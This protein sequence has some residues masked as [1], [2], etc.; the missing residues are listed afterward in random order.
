MAKTQ[1]Q[2]IAD[3]DSK[4]TQLGDASKTAALDTLGKNL[5]GK[6]QVSTAQTI[7]SDI[8]GDTRNQEVEV[9][10]SVRTKDDAKPAPAKDAPKPSGGPAPKDGAPKPATSSAPAPAGGPAPTTGGDK[11]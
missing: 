5:T 6:V 9:G 3:R 10:Y 11:K 1:E 4:V 7:T 2:L 8:D